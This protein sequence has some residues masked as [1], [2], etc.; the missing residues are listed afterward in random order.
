M[1]HLFNQWKDRNIP[2]G[3]MSDIYDGAV[4]QSFQYINEEELLAGRYCLGLLINIDWFQPYKHTEY[5]VGAIYIS[6]LNFPRQLRYCRE[7]MIVVG[8][9]PGPREPKLV[10][11][12]Y[13]ECLVEDLLKLWKGVKML[14]P[15]GQQVVKAILIC[16]ASDVPASR[17]MGG[18]VGHAAQ[19]GCSRCLKSFPTNRFGE[20]KNYSG[21]NRSM[22]PKRSVEQHRKF[23]MNWKLATTQSKRHEIEQ[24]YGV[25]YTEL[26][27][28][29]YFDTIRYVVVDPMH[30]VLLGTAKL[31]VTLWKA[32]GVLSEA[33]FN[34]IQSTVDKFI[35]P[36]DVGRIPHKISSQFSSFT[37]DQWKN[38]TLIYSVIVLKCII[39]EVHYECWYVFVEACRLL[40]SRS[41]SHDGVAKLDSLLIRFCQKFEEVYGASSC[42]PNIHLHGHLK[43]CILDFGPASSFWAFP[44]ERLNGMLGSVPTNHQSIETQLM[45]KFSSN[46]FVLQALKN[47][48]DETLNELFRR[49]QNPMGSLKHEEL[50]ELPLL[51]PLSILNVKAINNFC[52]LLPPIKEGYLNAEEHSY[53]E[54]V[55]KQCFGVAYIRTLLIYKYSNG[56]RFNGELY[57]SLKSIHSSSAMIYAKSRSDR[58][59]MAPAFV[60]KFV[61]ANVI[62][63]LCN[64]TEECVDIYLSAINWLKEH[65]EK[66]WFKYP[67]EVWREFS[68]AQTAA[69]CFVFVSDIKCRCAYL[70]DVVTFSRVLSETVTIVVP[71]SSF[72][73]L[74]V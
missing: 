65:P 15:E 41:I 27:R 22:W 2:S 53:I 8:I 6:I 70:I 21:F 52:Q 9:I 7:N 68:Y 16:A 14:T 31:M 50:P 4:W 55:M 58:G 61:K 36:A 25:R 44:F 51:S 72:A 23:G 19:K 39:P 73:G 32:N 54:D 69:E 60:R 10:M 62:L 71:L 3:V 49:F 66:T 20:K 56:L 74:D 59:H 48:N 33:Q 64:E 45:R 17:K 40:C 42:T 46:Q 57:G 63:K 18:F 12:S 13:L 43:E 11:N 37:A 34:T 28:L 24:K 5:S 26:L 47:S 30:N 67:V 35:T 38:W 29:P 1:L